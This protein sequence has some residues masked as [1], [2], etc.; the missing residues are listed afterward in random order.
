VSL[1]VLARLI[2]NSSQL[3]PRSFRIERSV[4]FFLLMG[5]IAPANA[6]ASSPRALTV[7][8]WL[9]S[10]RLQTIVMTTCQQAPVLQNLILPIAGGQT[11]CV[12]LTTRVANGWCVPADSVLLSLCLG[13]VN[14]AR[15]A[16]NRQLA[17][18]V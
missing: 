3:A 8:V 15:A 4:N 10:V 16:A 14:L 7:C 18:C 2:H 17:S 6:G 5:T 12:R 13:A 9:S 11:A 1:L